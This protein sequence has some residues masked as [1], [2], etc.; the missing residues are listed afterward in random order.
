MLVCQELSGYDFKGHCPGND[1]IHRALSEGVK[2]PVV[3][4]HEVGLEE[5]AGAPVV[6][7]YAQV[8]LHRDIKILIVQGH[9]LAAGIPKYLGHVVG[10]VH[11]ANEKE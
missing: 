5:V 3:A 7:E 9:K 8:E 2:P 10:T 1:S 6:L 4:T 11:S